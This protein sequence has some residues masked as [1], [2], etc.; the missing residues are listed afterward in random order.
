MKHNHFIITVAAL[1][2]IQQLQAQSFTA[3]QIQELIN[4]K[5]YAFE[6]QT[7]NP[8]RGGTKQLTTEYFLK[9]S[10]DS[11]SSYL[12]YFGRAYTAPMNAADNDY[13]FTSTKFDY[14]VSAGKKDSYKI[15]IK[16]KDRN[17]NTSFE[18][19]VYDNGNAYLHVTNNDREPVSFTG[20]IKR[21]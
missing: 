4:D 21:K 11:L 19:T 15:S 2:F 10:G 6:A 3:K 1:F 12:P 9:V 18:L 5:H 14:A 17:S 13:D 8:Q 16:T 7:M 20:Y